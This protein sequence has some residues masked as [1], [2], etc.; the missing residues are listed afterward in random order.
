MNAFEASDCVNFRGVTYFWSCHLSAAFFYC[1]RSLLGHLPS[2][3]YILFRDRKL[4]YDEYLQD[5]TAI[6]S[7]EQVAST[8]RRN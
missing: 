5:E 1:S 2:F 3:P 8:Q 4:L 7:Q 6:E